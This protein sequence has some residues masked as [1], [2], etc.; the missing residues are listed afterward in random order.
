MQHVDYQRALQ[1]ELEKTIESIDGVAAATV[2]LTIPHRPVF[3]GATED[4]PTAAVLVKTDGRPTL[5]G[6]A[7]Q[8]IVHLV[9]SSIPNMTPDDVT[10]ADANGT[11]L[12]APGMDTQLGGQRPDRA[13][14]DLRRHAREEDRG[15]GR[16]RRSGPATPRCTVAADLDMSKSTSDDD[17]RTPSRS[18]GHRPSRSRS[19]D[20]TEKF[21]RSRGTRRANGVLG[22]TTN[23]AAGGTDRRRPRRRRATQKTTNQTQQRGQLDGHD[24]TTTPPGTIKR[25]SVSVLLDSAVVK[26]ARRRD[27]LAAEHPGRGRHRHQARRRDVVKVTTVAFDKTAQK[28]AKAQLARRVRRRTRCSISSGTS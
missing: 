6:D 27:D 17:Q 9:A 10:V 23:P 20:T 24:T 26:P 19:N 22:V 18:N 1:G 3:V 28:A 2:N 13:D 4:K 11:V 12:H 21:G 8:A 14:P 15:H 25:L 7:V 16:P 5:S